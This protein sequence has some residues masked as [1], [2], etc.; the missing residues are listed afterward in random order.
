MKKALSEY[1]LI[2]GIQA[3]KD[4][5][6]KSGS[7]RKNE[8]LAKAQ[9]NSLTDEERQELIKSIDGSS[10]S[11]DVMEGLESDSINKSIDV[12]EFLRDTTDGV[13][14]GMQKLADSIEKSA[15]D[16]HTYR[17]HLAHTLLSLGDIIKSQ[18]ESLDEQNELIKSQNEY[19]ESL[20]SRLGQVP[21]RAPKSAG[22][23]SAQPMHKSFAG[24]PAPAREA[25]T[26]DGDVLSKSQILDVMEEMNKSSISGYSPSGV[27]IMAAVADYELSN[28]L[29]PR[30]LRD[31]AEF[32]KSRHN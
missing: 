30:M 22:I 3:L 24:S 29:D 21:A 19:L 1:D 5:A 32:R 15:N 14:S 26:L 25:A 12:S 20:T 17:V 9:R 6:E 18:R 2:K 23:P 16:A 11:R 10:L 13:R 7:S 4:A 28:A 27:P 8:L 31:I